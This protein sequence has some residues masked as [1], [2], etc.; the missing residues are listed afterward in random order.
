MCAPLV[1]EL[2]HRILDLP[3]DLNTL[4]ICCL[5][6]KDAIFD[7][8]ID[9]VCPLLGTDL[10]KGCF[11]GLVADNPPVSAGKVCLA[12][13]FHLTA[14]AVGPASESFFFKFINLDAL[15]SAFVLDDKLTLVDLFLM[16]GIRVYTELFRDHLPGTHRAYRT[17]TV[18]TNHDNIVKIYL[19]SLCK[20]VKGH[21]V[22]TLAG[23]GDLHALCTVGIVL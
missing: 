16:D 19:V 10:D 11:S 7:C 13:D 1:S 15:V 14:T 2:E 8:T 17:T 6:C 4:G 12:G 21:D 23:Y 18:D 22:T 3:A 20:L 9:E 5:C